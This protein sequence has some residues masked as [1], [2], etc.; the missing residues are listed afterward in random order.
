MDNNEFAEEWKNI[1]ID[2]VISNYEISNSGIVRNKTN[3][4]IKQPT[5]NNNGYYRVALSHNNNG[6]NYYIHRLI[7]I[8]FIPNP[9]NKP[10]IDHINNNPLDNRIQNLR[11]C[12]QS[13]NGMNHKIPKNN[14][15]GFKGIN[16]YKNRWCARITINNK[17]KN[18]G[19]FENLQDA[20]NA[21]R[22]ASNE[23]FGEFQNA[24]EK[25]I[26]I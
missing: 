8:Y 4:Y 14:T 15:S 23:L 5:L 11:W 2:D 18:L 7:A 22:T 3:G 21:R 12:N 1:I 26:L 17:N 20:I 24:C 10:I 6:K 19:R 9:D 25:D 13:E 16:W